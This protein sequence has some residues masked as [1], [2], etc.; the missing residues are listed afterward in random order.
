LWGEVNK[1]GRIGCYKAKDLRGNGCLKIGVKSRGTQLEKDSSMNPDVL[2]IRGE[3]EAR[4]SGGEISVSWGALGG[5]GGVEMKPP[6]GENEE[7]EGQRKSSK[8][9]GIAG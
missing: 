9:G 5:G 3:R 1:L 2:P 7:R 6:I 4:E 8:L